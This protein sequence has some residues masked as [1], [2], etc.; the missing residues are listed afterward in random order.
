MSQSVRPLPWQVRQAA[1]EAVRQALARRG[2]QVRPARA[3]TALKA[4]TRKGTYVQRALA[5]MASTG[6]AVISL[7]ERQQIEIDGNS[8]WSHN[9]STIARIMSACTAAVQGSATRQRA[10]GPLNVAVASVVAGTAAAGVPVFGWRVRIDGSKNAYAN[11]PVTVDVGPISRDAG[12]VLSVPNPV[13]T[14][15]MY[16]QEY[17]D[18]LV[19]AVGNAGSIATIV[20]GVSGQAI[21]ASTTTSAPGCLIRPLDASTG[22]VTFGQVIG[23]NER[24]L[25][26][27]VAPGGN[28]MGDGELALDLDGE[29]ALDDVFSTGVSS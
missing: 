17:L 8:V 6:Y 1:G 14:F 15:T 10:N 28:I 12:T 24:D 27:K 21:A 5:L 22:P 9:Y 3:T 23:L 26:A 19:L 16:G 13:L 4:A 7:R 29:L 11:Q 20:P 18:A 25:H 2:P